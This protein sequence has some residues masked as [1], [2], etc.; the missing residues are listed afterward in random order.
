MGVL[1]EK[2]LALIKAAAKVVCLDRKKAVQAVDRKDCDS[3][4]YLE[5][6][7][8]DVTADEKAYEM[9]EWLER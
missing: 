2:N 3:V 9:V 1:K 6:E 8:A 5:T 7:K 4:A